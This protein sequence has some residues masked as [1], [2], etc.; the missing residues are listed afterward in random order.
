MVRFKLIKNDNFGRRLGNV[1]KFKLI[2]N[3][4]FGSRLCNVVP[5]S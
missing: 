3:D 5:L 4:N 2:T 1:V